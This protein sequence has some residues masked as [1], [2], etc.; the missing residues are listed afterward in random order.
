MKKILLITFLVVVLGFSALA[1]DADRVIHNQD[2]QV[3]INPAGSSSTTFTLQET[4]TG[5]IIVNQP[6]PAG[7]GF[8]N[9]KLTCSLQGVSAIKTIS[10]STTGTGTVSGTLVGKEGSSFISKVVTGDTN[11]PKTTTCTPYSC[12]DDDTKYCNGVYGWVGCGTSKVCKKG[13]G[14]IISPVCEE[15]QSYSS[16]VGACVA[17]APEL[18]TDTDANATYP[19]GDNIRVK[20]TTTLGAQ[21]NTDYCLPNGNFYEYYCLDE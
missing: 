3:N 12:S 20:G 5:S 18:C 21:S 1:W 16:D 17:N 8:A 4:F 19:T 7:C 9:S 10:Y 2:V 13:I 6:Y 15:S 14:C 11:I